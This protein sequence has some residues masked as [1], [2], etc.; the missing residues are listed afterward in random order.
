VGRKWGIED[1]LHFCTVDYKDTFALVAE[2]FKE[3]RWEIVAIG[4]WG[5]L[6][7]CGNS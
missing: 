5:K 7:K 3:H 4:R 6:K 1:A 2:A